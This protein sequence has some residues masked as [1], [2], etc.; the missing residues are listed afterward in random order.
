MPETV[1]LPKAGFGL[2]VMAFYSHKEPSKNKRNQHINIERLIEK[3]SFFDHVF[4]QIVAG[5]VFASKYFINLTFCGFTDKKLGRC[6]FA[7]QYYLAV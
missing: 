6:A 1:Y 4:R 3:K 5:L 2:L 7:S